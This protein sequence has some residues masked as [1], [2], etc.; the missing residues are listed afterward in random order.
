VIIIIGTVGQK[1][2]LGSSDPPFLD[3]PLFL[4]VNISWFS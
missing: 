4:D 3:I 1:N 2:S